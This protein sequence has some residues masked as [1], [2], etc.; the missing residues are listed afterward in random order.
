MDSD[1]Q[2]SCFAAEVQ[3][4]SGYMPLPSDMRTSILMDTEVPRQVKCANVTKHDDLNVSICVE[5][6]AQRNRASRVRGRGR[7]AVYFCGL[8]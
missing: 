2:E 3:L 5:R 1:E 8:V 4:V 6:A 7:E